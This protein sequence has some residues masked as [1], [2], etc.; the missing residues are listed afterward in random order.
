MNFSPPVSNQKVPR[1]PFHKFYLLDS[2]LVQITAGWQFSIPEYYISFIF[3]YAKANQLL[4]SFVCRLSLTF[5]HR[6]TNLEKGVI[7]SIW[8][9]VWAFESVIVFPLLFL[10]ISINLMFNLI[11]LRASLPQICQLIPA[12]TC[13]SPQM[14]FYRGFYIWNLLSY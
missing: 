2:K 3:W 1:V 14:L 4:P 5:S 6:G 9:I 8:V 10:H 13:T 12:A 7:D 11:E